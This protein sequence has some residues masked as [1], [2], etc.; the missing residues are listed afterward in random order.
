GSTVRMKI[1]EPR[2]ADIAPTW[3]TIRVLTEKDLPF[4]GEI[5][6]NPASR[7]I[8]ITPASVSGAVSLNAFRISD[9]QGS[10]GNDFTGI[11]D[12]TADDD[13]APVEYFN[14]QGIRV[15]NPTPGLYIRRQGK[16]VEK[17]VV[18]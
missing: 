9:S 11:A 13:N 5:D 16:K 17:V 2:N 8:K 6:L 15:D 1:Q 12:I 7:F 3:R 10:F 14:L 18:R 4:K